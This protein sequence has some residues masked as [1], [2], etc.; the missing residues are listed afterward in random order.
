VELILAGFA[1]IAIIDL[2]PLLKNRS[3]IEAIVFLVLFIPALTLALLE[4]KGIGAPSIMV[5]L[6]ALLKSIGLSY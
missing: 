2:L 4:Y 6:D 5:V 1:L 3:W